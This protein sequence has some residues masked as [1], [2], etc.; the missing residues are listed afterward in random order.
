MTEMKNRRAVK[1]GT[2]MAATSALALSL[3]MTAQAADSNQIKGEH[4][5]TTTQIKGETTQM[6]CCYGDMAQ[7]K[8]GSTQIKGEHGPTTTQIKG[9][10]N[11]GKLTTGYLKHDTEFLKHNTGSSNQLKFESN[12]LKM[13]SLQH[14]GDS[15]QIKLH[16]LD[17]VQHKHDTPSTQLNPQP[18]PPKPIGGSSTP[19]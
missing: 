5:P 14:K 1:I 2:L 7:H 3:G 10:T 18:E 9:E 6:K 17:V 12:Q 11:Q 16:N 19:H 13:D 15:T 8:I 4:G